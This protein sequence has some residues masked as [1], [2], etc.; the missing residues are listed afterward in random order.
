MRVFLSAWELQIQIKHWKIDG[1]L[2]FLFFVE[3]DLM[4]FM[5]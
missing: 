4:L 2:I 5:F 1:M 3:V